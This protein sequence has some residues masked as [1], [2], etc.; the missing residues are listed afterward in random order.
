MTNF[1]LMRQIIFW[2]SLSILAM[3]CSLKPT[4]DLKG[5]IGR[6]VAGQ[7][8]LFQTGDSLNGTFINLATGDEIPL[9]GEI[10][11]QS[12]VLKEFAEGQAV[13]GYFEGKW[14]TPIFSG[15]WISSDRSKRVPFAFCAEAL[16]PNSEEGK[17]KVNI[18][19][20]YSFWYEEK[21]NSGECCDEA[22]CKKT[23]HSF[24]QSGEVW[25]C[26]TGLP[27]SVFFFLGDLNHDGIIDG[28]SEIQTINCD[29]GNRNPF[30]FFLAILSTH[31]GEYIFSQQFEDELMDVFGPIAII[32]TVLND[33]IIG[34]K[35]TYVSGDANCC[36]SI[37][38]EVVAAFKNGRFVQVK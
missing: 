24:R 35:F 28:F 27:D 26:M 11:G 37:E 25:A 20:A 22:T 31:E 13:T 3:G 29:G 17:S 30:T 23:F 36:P 9:R 8:A 32:D 33:R 34:R 18:Q 14:R 16:I 10:N 7:I 2:T 15:N 6:S 12:I 4:W 19:I 5:S 38:E 1:P 21:L